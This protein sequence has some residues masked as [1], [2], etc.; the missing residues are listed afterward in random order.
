MESPHRDDVPRTSESVDEQH[1]PAFV[2]SEPLP[3]QTDAD[4]DVLPS[5]DARRS[6]DAMSR[7]GGS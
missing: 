1:P 3:P 4:V 2:E 5:P 7:S 6:L